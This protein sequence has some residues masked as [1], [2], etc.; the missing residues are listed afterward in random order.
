MKT[1]TKQHRANSADDAKPFSVTLWGSNPD[2]TD[3]DDCWTGDEFATREEAVLAYREIVMF[4]DDAQLSRVCGRGGW[5][6]VMIDGPDTHEV[7]QNPD[8]R[9]CERRRRELER[10][11]A[12]WQR[13]RAME[14]G[15]LF[16]VEA[17]NDEMGY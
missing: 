11:D 17:Y 8:R 13:E 5:E 15:M 6:Y 3:N 1:S 4:P 16:G 2:E 9:A 10:A 14:A 12:D 7:T